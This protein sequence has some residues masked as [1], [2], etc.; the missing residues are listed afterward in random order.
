M[1]HRKL[2]IPFR[3]AAN[4]SYVQRIFLTQSPDQE[5]SQQ[6]S[7]K[8]LFRFISVMAF[9]KNKH[10]L[11]DF[12]QCVPPTTVLLMYLT[13]TQL[14]ILLKCQTTVLG[15]NCLIHKECSEELASFTFTSVFLR[16][17][18]LRKNPV[19]PLSLHVGGDWRLP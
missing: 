15:K 16:L 4:K 14:V 13:I 19:Q 1:K 7:S 8:L 10:F 12:F 9:K 2:S 18:Q 17:V 11:H 6:R 5:K 3:W